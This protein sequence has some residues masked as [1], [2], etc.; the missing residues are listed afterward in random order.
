L[1]SENRTHLNP[2]FMPPRAKT[3]AGDSEVVGL[4][5]PAPTVVGKKS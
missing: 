5:E 2:T 1:L 3:P 4:V